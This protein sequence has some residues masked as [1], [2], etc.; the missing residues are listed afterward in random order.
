ML[1]TQSCLFATP[2]IVARQA[3]LSM[4][5]P[6]QEYWNGLPL[7]PPEDLLNPGIKPRSPTLPFFTIILYRLSFREPTLSKLG[8]NDH[9]QFYFCS[10][11]TESAKFHP[12]K[13]VLCH[14]AALFTPCSVHQ[15]H[16]FPRGSLILFIYHI[17]IKEHSN[18]CRPSDKL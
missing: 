15:H 14:F 6:R 11:I 13:I 18:T 2:Q 3:P 9:S 10:R 17:M 4:G 16:I 5:L 8:S 12:P 1:V 7:T